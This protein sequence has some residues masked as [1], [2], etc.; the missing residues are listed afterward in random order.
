MIAP[1]NIL[2][3]QFQCAREVV[4]RLFRMILRDGNAK[5]TLPRE[6]FNENGQS[7]YPREPFMWE[8]EINVSTEIDWVGPREQYLHG[9][10]N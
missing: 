10:C 1:G 9:N 4:N 3:G 2:Y 6:S 8:W 5:Q 7:G